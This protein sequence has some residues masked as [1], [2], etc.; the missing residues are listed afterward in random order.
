MPNIPSVP[1]TLEALKVIQRFV[2]GINDMVVPTKQ[3]SLPT[4]KPNPMPSRVSTGAPKTWKSR[5]ITILGE[6]DRPLRPIDVSEEYRQ[7]GWPKP[8]KSKIPVLVRAT[9]ADLKRD[10]FVAHEPLGSTYRLVED[11]GH[12]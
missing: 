11:R 1:E 7:R 6:A 4:A 10:G 8:G 12:E 5:I 2:E 3:V 9:L